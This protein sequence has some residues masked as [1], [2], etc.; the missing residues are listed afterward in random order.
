MEKSADI[1]GSNQSQ[2]NKWSVRPRK[3]VRGTIRLWKYWRQ[4][5]YYIQTWEKTMDPQR[6]QYMYCIEKKKKNA[7]RQTFFFC[8]MVYFQ[9]EGGVSGTE[10]PKIQTL[11]D[12]CLDLSTCT[13]GPQRWS[14]ITQKWYLP[15]KVFLFPQNR[16]FNTFLKWFCARDNFPTKVF[17][18]PQNRPFNIFTL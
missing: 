3:Y 13:E 1:W 10:T 16:S 14:F 12:P 9:A 7:D 18:F 4:V 8:L 6:R 17:F 11:P 15:T 5:I 2:T